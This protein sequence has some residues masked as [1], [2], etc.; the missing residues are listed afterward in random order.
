MKSDYS[1]IVISLKTAEG[2]PS[3]CSN[4]SLASMYFTDVRSV[5]AYYAENSYGL[6]HISGTVTGP[7]VVSLEKDWT[8][9][10]VANEADAAATAAGVNLSLYSQKIYILPKEADPNPIQ[11][12]WGG[13]TNGLGGSRLWIRDYW[14]SSRWAAAHE[15]GHNLGLNHAATPAD[16][17]GDFSSSMGG[18][19]DPTS[20]P[21]TWNNMLHY[22]APEKVAAGWL[23]TSAVQTVTANGRFRVASVE[24]V[25]A[26]GQI[27]A[28][29]IK[30]A[31]GGTDYYYFSYR[32]AVGFSSVL[33]PQYAA[34]TSVTRWNG[35]IGSNT[36]LLATL[37][38]GQ[39][40]ADVSGLMVAQS[41]HDA[42]HANITVT[43]GFA[44]YPTVVT[45]P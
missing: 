25:P 36:C 44:S 33:T 31:N 9:P 13:R 20:D 29:K 11:S 6:L 14:C 39:A 18:R 34:L 26:P 19:A 12:A 23:P 28:L 7:H 17:Y 8:P 15:L 40:F 24:T 3:H 2:P 30:G 4:A 45:C 42:T 41:S 32:Q 35:S 5:N 38:D 1:T 16:E 37:A 43:F 10:S 22:N 27:Q 21:S